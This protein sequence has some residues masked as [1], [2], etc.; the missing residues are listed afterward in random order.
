V[1]S[2]M[3]I[4]DRSPPPH[5]PTIH[6]QGGFWGQLP[7]LAADSA[8]RISGLAPSDPQE[9]ESALA[10]EIRAGAK[11]AEER[12]QEA[13]SKKAGKGTAATAAPAP[14]ACGASQQQLPM[15]P[16]PTTATPSAAPFT[17]SLRSPLESPLVKRAEVLEH[18]LVTGME[19]LPLLKRWRPTLAVLTLDN[20]LHLFDLPAVST[21]A[22]ALSPKEAF[23]AL[24]PQP[25]DSKGRFRKVKE[26]ERI[27]PTASLVLDRSK[28]RFRPEEG[29]RA[30]EVTESTASVGI[31]KVFKSHETRRVILRAKSQASM[32]DWCVIVNGEEHAA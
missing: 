10:E 15:P 17:G 16:P 6:A 13:A 21:A 14:S 29:D 30:F 5:T 7:Q 26:A 2:E 24:V 32:V 8:L 11:A 22:E 28:A 12:E 18:K 1:G 19:S 4:R 25:L 9:V 27:K 3:C 31:A 20:A 23:R